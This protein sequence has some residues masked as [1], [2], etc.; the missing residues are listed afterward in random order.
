MH[1][2]FKLYSDK[3]TSDH[4]VEGYRAEGYLVPNERLLVRNFI[5]ISVAVIKPKAIPGISWN[6]QHLR[7]FD[8]GLCINHLHDFAISLLLAILGC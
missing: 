7:D 5:W 6:I 8:S 2:N 3:A 1:C 4:R